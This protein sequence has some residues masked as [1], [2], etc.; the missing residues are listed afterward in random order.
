MSAHV[1]TTVAAHDCTTVTAHDGVAALGRLPDG[2]T[3]AEW[4]CAKWARAERSHARGVVA[5][6]VVAHRVYELISRDL[7]YFRLKSP[8]IWKLLKIIW[9]VSP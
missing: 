3:R 7:E 8:Q 5:M 1:G 9:M 4:S 6:L 2:R